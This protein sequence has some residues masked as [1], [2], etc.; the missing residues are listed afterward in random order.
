MNTEWFVYSNPEANEQIASMLEGNCISEA[1][2]LHPG[3]ECNDGIK[4]DLWQVPQDFIK[5]LLKWSGSAGRSAGLQ[6]SI[7][8]RNSSFA[9]PRHAYYLGKGRTPNAITKTKEQLSQLQHNTLHK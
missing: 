9:K 6:V 5:K 8:S 3:M 2:C 1:E 7:Y 4:R